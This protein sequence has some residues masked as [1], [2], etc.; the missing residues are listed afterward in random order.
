MRLIAIGDIHGQ[1]KKLERLL[2]RV[3]LRPD[4]R[5]VFLGDYVDRGADSCGVVACLLKI[6]RSRPETIFLRGNHEQLLLDALAEHGSSA[7][8]T[9]AELSPQFATSAGGS[10]TFLHLLNGGGATLASYGISSHAE[11][12]PPDHLDFLHQT[13]LF[14]SRPPF[15]F[16]HAGADPDLDPSVQD[17]FTLLWDRTSPPGRNGRIHIIGHQPTMDGLPHFT[18]GCYRLDT[19]AGHSGPLTACDVLTR[20]YWQV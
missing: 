3:A 10:A 13:R 1:R 7:L 6:G 8:P 11:G 5:L 20:E 4:D 16:V 15:L 9:L 12:L 19:G 2:D 17:P 18:A 14:W